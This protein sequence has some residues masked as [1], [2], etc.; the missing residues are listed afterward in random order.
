[1]TMGIFRAAAALAIAAA[2]VGAS[3][4][5]AG[6]TWTQVSVTPAGGDP[7]NSSG[8]PMVTPNGRFVAFDSGATDL[9]DAEGNESNDVF[10]R[11]LREGVTEL[12]SA[13]A[14]GLEGNGGSRYAGISSNGRW[15]AFES[16][17]TDLVAGDTA[18][19][20]VFAADRRSGDIVKVSV[21]HDGA[22]AD[23][24]SASY[25]AALSGNGRWVVFA[26][27]A[28]NL[29]ADVDTQGY[30]QVYLRDLR[31]GT[32]R[33]VSHDAAGDG[34]GGTC[35]NPSISAN[36]RFVAFH[37]NAGDLV[38][39]GSNGYNHVYVWDSRRDAFLRASVN[40]LGALGNS[41]SFDGVVSN[42]GRRVAFYGYASALVPPD[43]NG[44]TD[45][46]LK[47]L[48]TG[49]V[50]SLSGGSLDGQSYSP[51]ISASG[52]TVAFYSEADDLV[53]GDDNSTGDVFVYDVKAG[54][55]TRASVGP[56]GVDGNGYSF[57][58]APS[59][60]SNGKWLAIASEADNLDP[61]GPADA[62]GHSDV[63]LTRLK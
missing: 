29:V 61:D 1:M 13:N 23:D 31:T 4:Q 11:D 52:K 32:T 35:G 43:A 59:L 21:G 27:K 53:E 3:A 20:D 41:D 40:A 44:G 26:S 16:S 10:V 15:V 38:E 2:A 28:T 45:T 47:D 58:Y 17:A 42:N 24:D 9:L 18:T 34:C 7:D 33:L 60:S 25:G 55:L 36:G 56:E 14:E 6:P 57:L 63:F 22:L 46:Y 8:E 12:V 5:D 48:S 39:G 54:V 19:R 51:T 30:D 50:W 62:S 49:E 37:S